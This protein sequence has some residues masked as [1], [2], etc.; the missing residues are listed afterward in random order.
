MSSAN[1]ESKLSQSRD[2][3][4]KP[5]MTWIESCINLELM[6][7]LD[8]EEEFEFAFVGFDSK[9]DVERADLAT[10][11]VKAFKTVNEVRVEQGL[12][13]RDDCDIILDSTF[14]QARSMA[15]QAEQ[16]AQQPAQGVDENGQ[17]VGGD[18]G[19][20]APEGAQG[21]Q[22][23]PVGGGEDQ[24]ADWKTWVAQDQAKQQ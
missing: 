9:S 7:A 21:A 1:E 10:K 2:K 12:D 19:S 17:P 8:P 16:Q 22:D 14:M 23:G 20:G 6:P 24:G 3:G 4:L 13:E 18:D 15:Q 11:Q 5:L